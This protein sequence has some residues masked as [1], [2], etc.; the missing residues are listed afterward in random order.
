MENRGKLQSKNKNAM[1]SSLLQPAFR[2]FS[3]MN[4]FFKAGPFLPSLRQTH[5]ILPLPRT[6]FYSLALSKNEIRAIRMAEAV[7]LAR[8]FPSQPYFI[9][10]FI[11]FFRVF[12]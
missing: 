7:H 2:C 6:T 1:H 10:L 4:F 8:Y 12:L 5:L 9:V 3:A 11:F